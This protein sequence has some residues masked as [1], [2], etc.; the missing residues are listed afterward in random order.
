MNI[1]F[2]FYLDKRSCIIF[3]S[4]GTYYI[5]HW[6]NKT[7]NITKYAEDSS[8]GGS[9]SVPMQSKL[10]QH[11]GQ[12]QSSRSSHYKAVLTKVIKKNCRTNIREAYSC[13]QRSTAAFSVEP[14]QY[15][16]SFSLP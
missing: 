5:S 12:E 9:L 11:H 16:I 8:V 7:V 6:L 10:C 2:I 15:N 4:I 3:I 1:A 14:A 13:R